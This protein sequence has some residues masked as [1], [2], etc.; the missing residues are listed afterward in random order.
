MWR[1]TGATTRS[2][3]HFPPRLS[4]GRRKDADTVGEMVWFFQRGGSFVRFESRTVDE[5]REIFE[6]VVIEPDGTEQREVFENSEQLLQRQM[7]LERDLEHD[8]WQGPFGR[9]F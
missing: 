9:V 1:V 7:E 4:K 3:V 5:S 6:L 8:G 2:G